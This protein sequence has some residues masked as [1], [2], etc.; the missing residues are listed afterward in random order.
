[1]P[2][3]V[4]YLQSGSIAILMSGEMDSLGNNSVR[5]S[6]AAYNNASGYPLA[7]I[8][9]TGGAK[10]SYTQST[11]LS[12]WFLRSVVSGTYEDGASGFVPARPPNTVIPLVS[13]SQIVSRICQIP[14]QTFFTLLK[15][16]GT[17]V[18]LASSG[19]VLRLYPLTF[20]ASSG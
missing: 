6:T 14:P 12:V 13:G 9:F 1:M 16:D 11:G 5:L 17:G 8:E 7:E 10:Q 2:Q 4:N 3:S 20:Q 15:N 19:N 18:S